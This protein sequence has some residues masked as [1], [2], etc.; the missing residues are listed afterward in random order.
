VTRLDEKAKFGLVYAGLD[1]HFPAA[2]KTAVQNWG[3]AGLTLTKIALAATAAIGLMAC[4]SMAQGQAPAAPATAA[5][6]AASAPAAVSPAASAAADPAV[7]NMVE[8]ACSQ[9][10]DLTMLSNNPRSAA[11]WAETVQTM[12]DRGA[13]LT[14]DQAKI[15]VAYLAKTYPPK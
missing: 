3:V 7:A 10:H 9:C 2:V 5:V 12:R 1:D 15:A 4:G 14:D 13:K 11:D 6:P 8:D